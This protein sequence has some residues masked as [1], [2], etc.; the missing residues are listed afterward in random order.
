MPANSKVLG[1]RSYGLESRLILQS[2]IAGVSIEGASM[3]GLGQGTARG[4]VPS[5]RLVIYK[6]CYEDECSDMDLMVAFDDAIQDGVDMISLSVGG[7]LSDYFSDAIAIGSF[8]AMKKGILTSGSSGLLLE[9]E[10]ARMKMAQRPDCTTNMIGC[11]NRE[12]L[13][14]PSPKAGMYPLTSAAQAW[15]DS[16]Q[17]PDAE[18]YCFVETLDTNK[19][20]GKIVLCKG[21]SDSDI[22][23]IGGVG[24]IVTSDD[25]LDTGVTLVL[26]TALVN[27]ER[28]AKMDKYINPTKNPYAVISKSKTVNV[29]A[30]FVASFSSRGPNLVSPTISKPDIVA[31]RI[32]V[33]AACSKLVAV[34]G[35]TMDNR[36]DAC[37]IISRTAMACPHATGVAA[38]IKTFH[39]EWSP[40]TIK[41]AFMTTASEMKIGDLFAEWGSS[42]GQI[43]PTK[44]L[45]LGLIYELSERSY[46]FIIYS[47]AIL[48]IV[49]RNENT[50]CSTISP[51]GAH[52][53]LN[54]ASMNVQVENP[55]SSTTIAFIR[56]VINVGPENH[57]TRQW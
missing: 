7:P 8:H 51:F 55:Q 22:K 17:M 15:N 5:S 54:Y 14:T 24:M 1:A 16:L 45:D 25:S 21:G 49:T 34:T 35:E 47:E 11:T 27:S 37:N 53:A 26:P 33:L 23:E 44:A 19:V 36:V 42:A 46:P 57:L 18:G 3:Y 38:Y 13:S 39:P 40:A 41:S 6:V 52:D 30:P 9:L 4:A 2:T 31:P 10:M 56:T 48:S 50:N 20:K 32:D 29:S 43:D 12:F 28:G